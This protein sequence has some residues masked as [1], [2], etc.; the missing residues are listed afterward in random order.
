MSLFSFQEQITHLFPIFSDNGGLHFHEII[1]LVEQEDFSRAAPLIEEGFS[2]GLFD[3]R[4]IM[5]FLYA[6]F[7]Q[8]KLPSL[9]SIF[10]LIKSLCQEHWEKLNPQVKRELHFHKSLIWFL[11]RCG[12]NLEY[13]EKLNRMGDSSLWREYSKA[14]SLEVLEETQS[15]ASELQKLLVERW[16]HSSSHEKISGLLVVIKRFYIGERYEE[17]KKEIEESH[18]STQSDQEAI[19]DAMTRE[20]FLFSDNM[21]ILL[22]KMEAFELLVKEK[23][24]PKALIIF[25]DIEKCLNNFDPLAYLPK[26]FTRY[27]SLLAEHIDF[28]HGEMEHQESPLNMILSKLYKADL[29]IFLRWK[30]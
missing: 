21:M 13:V 30:S 12:K 19:S 7:I 11:T 16:P 28:L 20:T 15:Q 29:S 3:I 25:L 23:E 4:L 1:E 27:F 5:Y 10:P 9:S 14:L 22:K 2:K 6:Y 26:L 24:Y 18:L 17:S 8:N